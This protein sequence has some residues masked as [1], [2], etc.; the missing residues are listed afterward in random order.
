MSKKVTPIGA[1]A[2]RLGHQLN[3]HE[4]LREVLGTHVAQKGSL[5]AQDRLRFDFSHPK[6][7]GPD[8]IAAVEAEAAA[9]LEANK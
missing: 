5:V 6:A 3:L 2:D 7:L 1:K 8:D 4:A 9:W